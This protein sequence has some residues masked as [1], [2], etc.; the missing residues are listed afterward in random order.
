[1][2]DAEAQPDGTYNQI[3]FPTP[4]GWIFKMVHGCCN[5]VFRAK[6]CKNVLLGHMSHW[7]HK[8]KQK[9]KVPQSRSGEITLVLHKILAKTKNLKFVSLGHICLIFCCDNPCHDLKKRVLRVVSVKS[10]RWNLLR[11]LMHAF[12]VEKNYMQA[13]VISA[14]NLFVAIWSG[15]KCQNFKSCLSFDYNVVL[16]L[17]AFF[18]Q[19]QR[20]KKWMK[21]GHF[22]VT[23]SLCLC[24]KNQSAL[25]REDNKFY[26]A[27]SPARQNKKRCTL[28]C[29]LISS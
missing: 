12:C 26:L 25:G 11:N 6:N 18:V 22:C 7:I 27:R 20:R 19:E 4:V 9:F 28:S 23:E 2:L 16:V 15:T 17:V 8:K 5:H 10:W 21:T 29:T 14:V 1:M 24:Q 3:R 13:T